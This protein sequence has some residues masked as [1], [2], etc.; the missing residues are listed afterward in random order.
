MAYD[1]VTV[2]YADILRHELAAKPWDRT[3]LATFAE[4][5]RTADGGRVADLGCGSG[6]VTAYLHDLGLDVSGIDLSPQ[7]V[8]VSS[9]E[10]PHLRFDV[11]SMTGLDLPD[12]VLGG[13]LAR[14]SLIPH[15]PPPQ[16][17]AVVAE[18]ARV[19]RAGGLLLTAF[20]VGDER[21]RLTHAYGHALYLDAY[22]LPPD[23]LAALLEGAG[24]AV[25]TRVV[26]EPEG[27][28][29]VAQAYLLGRKP[30]S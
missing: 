15:T 1:T 12:G 17:P 29:K 14:Y 22:R 19:L 8:A 6:R 4:L 3:L 2:D 10:H 27:Q 20:Q 24:L 16:L 23:E 21:V 25:S 28:E 7:M 13:V 11:G 9:R 30:G 5:V 18:L 26:R